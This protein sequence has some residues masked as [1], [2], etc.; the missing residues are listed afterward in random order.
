MGIIRTRDNA[1]GLVEHHIDARLGAWDRSTIDSD[2]LG[3]GIGLIPQL[4]HLLIDP[5]STSLYKRLTTTA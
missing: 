2:S 1:T 5:H 4:G 3:I